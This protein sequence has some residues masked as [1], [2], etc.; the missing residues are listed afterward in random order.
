MQN[1]KRETKPKKMSSFQNVIFL[2]RKTIRSRND[3]SIFSKGPKLSRG[4]LS[5]FKEQ[6]KFRLEEMEKNERA[7]Q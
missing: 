3:G 4:Y 2:A 7:A 5:N 6:M 1:E